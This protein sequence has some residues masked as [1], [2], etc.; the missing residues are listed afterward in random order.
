MKL[1]QNNSKAT[2]ALLNSLC[3]SIYTKVIHCK[4][5]K[6]IWGKLQNIYE[7]DSKVKAAEVS[8]LQRLVQTTKDEGR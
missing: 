6:E 8:N 4:S 5:A 1:G 3:E 7:G 2:N